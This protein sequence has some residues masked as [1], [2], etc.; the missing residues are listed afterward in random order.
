MAS[1]ILFIAGIFGSLL[2]VAAAE[3]LEPP[4]KVWERV[5]PWG[6][7]VERL[8]YYE[9]N[10]EKV[11]HGAH[12]SFS[13]DGTTLESRI[14]YLHGKEDGV[15]EFFYDVLGTKNTEMSYVAGEA[16]GPIRTWAPDGKLLFEGIWK[17]G[18]EHDGWFDQKST[19]GSG[20]FHRDSETWEIIQWKNGKMVPGSERK[21]EVSWRTWT[22]GKL[23]DHKMFILWNW[24]P[25]GVNSSYPF[26]ERMPIYS[27]IPFLIK[28]FEEQSEG[29]HEVTNQLMALTRVQFRDFQPDPERI[30]A[31]AKWRAWWEDVGKHRPDLIT[32]R[33]V[34]DSE[35]WD[36]AQRGRNLPIPE[37]PLVIPETYVLEVSFSSGDYGGVTS[38]TLTI[39]RN[40][41]GAELTRKF[42]TKSNGPVNE[43]RWVTFGEKEADRVVRA[44]GYLINRPWLLNDE[45]DIE[46]RYWAAEK[47]DP[48]S[49]SMVEWHD[50]IL[51]GRESYGTPYYPNVT[52][53]LRDEKGK[54]WWNAD[55]DDWDGANPPRFNQTHQ[56]VPGTVFPFLSALYPESTRSGGA[57]KPGWAAR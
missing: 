43:E 7:V 52:F 18:Q 9:K 15:S 51:K 35:A 33:G 57:N 24:L 53:E 21:V 50:D 25:Y 17:D 55:P 47:K 6:T 5:T 2:W 46:K 40:K 45:A 16:E 27:D 56:P 39:Q 28:C 10:G 36:L 14:R 42:S 11:E 32:E 37:E 54:I 49:E 48:E 4:L 23:P 41:E 3:E 38:E 29:S 19:G 31:T 12:E 26:K 44:V 8:T 30:R 20:M 13:P 22:P 34:K 1:R